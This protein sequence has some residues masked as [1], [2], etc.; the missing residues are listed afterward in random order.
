METLKNILT[1][2]KS[3]PSADCWDKLSANL[4]ATMPTNAPKYQSSKAP[5]YKGAHSFW[6]A[7]TKIA[8]AVVGTAVTATVVVV[9]VSKLSQ[10]PAPTNVPTPQTATTYT[11]TLSQ[12]TVN[13]DVPVFNTLNCTSTKTNVEDSSIVPNNYATPQ[14]PTSATLSTNLSKP[15]VAGGMTGSS[16]FL[17]PAPASSNSPAPT[18]TAQKPVT[19]PASQPATSTMADAH[20]DPAVQQ[21]PD[22]NIEWNQPAKLEIPNVFTPNGDGINDF[23]VIKGLDNCTKRQLVVRNIAGNIVYK[24]NSYENTWDGND[25]PDGVY[26][27]QFIFNNGHI[28]QSCIGNIYIKRK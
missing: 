1:N 10:T 15:S 2:Y 22:E 4:D 21:V 24:S 13:Q 25:C 27:Y 11:D 26:R 17:T 18:S 7:G 3:E 9:A 23:F 28:D 12:D 8:A 20:H 5:Q 16:H 14:S 19:A 6:T